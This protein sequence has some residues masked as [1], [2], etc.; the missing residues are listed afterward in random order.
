MFIGRWVVDAIVDSVM[1]SFDTDGNNTM[2]FDAF[3][4]MVS[5]FCWLLL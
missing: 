2:S 1:E 4:V 3:T 5:S